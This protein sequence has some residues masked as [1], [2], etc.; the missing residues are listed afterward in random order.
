MDDRLSNFPNTSILQRWETKH[1]ITRNVSSSFAQSPLAVL[2]NMYRVLEILKLEERD[3]QL[4]DTYLYLSFSQRQ[5]KWQSKW[6]RQSIQRLCTFQHM[7]STMWMW[8]VTIPYQQICH[9]LVFPEYFIPK[10]P[11]S[12]LEFIAL[13]PPRGIKTWSSLFSHRRSA[14]VAVLGG[15]V[16]LL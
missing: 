1:T 16:S 3:L 9:W 12:S 2:K 6:P 15:T 4:P 14:K 5:D 8:E 13:V 7:N 10:V 11:P